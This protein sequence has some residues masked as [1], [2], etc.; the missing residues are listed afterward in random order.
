LEKEGLFGL[1]VD[2]GI[3]DNRGLDD[4]TQVIPLWLGDEGVRG[5][6]KAMLLKDRCREEQVYLQR[7]LDRLVDW[8]VEEWDIVECALSSTS[9]SLGFALGLKCS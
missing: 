8:F 2:D 1:D 3:W 9:K 5:G 4:R 7:E 6:I